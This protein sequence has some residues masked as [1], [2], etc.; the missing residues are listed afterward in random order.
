MRQRLLAERDERLRVAKVERE[1]FE[2]EGQLRSQ[3]LKIEAEE[4]ALAELTTGGRAEAETIRW[5]GVALSAA[6]SEAGRTAERLVG[7][8]RRLDRAR[9]VLATKAAERRAI[10]LLKERQRAAFK[11]REDAAEVRM[12]DDLAAAASVRRAQGIN[13]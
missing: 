13:E 11:R 6:R 5:Q 1:R 4:R 2:I 8:L 7:V 3:Q 9:G 12:L 10:E